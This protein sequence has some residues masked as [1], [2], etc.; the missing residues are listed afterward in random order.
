MTICIAAIAKEKDKEYVVFSTDHMITTNMGQ[1][2]HSIVKYT[3]I[4]KHTIAMLAGH[5]LL[6]DDLIKFDNKNAKYD[7]IK[8]Q[9]F[10][11][12]KKKRKE[13][14]EN[15]IYNIV[16]IDHQCYIS[17]L[18]N[19]MMNPLIQ[20]ILQ[21]VTDFKLNTTVLLTGFDNSFVQI[22]AIE[23]TGILDFRP[24]NFHA[25]G[26]GYVQA[27]N[28]LLFQKHSKTDS[29]LNAIY[30]V[31]KAKRNAEVI[32]GVG[33]ET[34]ISIL[35]EKGIQQLSN[36]YIEVLNNI[37]SNEIQYGKNNENLNKIKI[38]VI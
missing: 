18:Q 8:K 30:N 32:V 6:F 34:D 14:I 11:N 23:E 3:Q 29:L 24:M 5:A 25:I 31:Y 2:E 13:I 10:E 9:I 33:K 16:G 4:N 21:K 7:D 26:S 38:G 17:S 28:T 35:S 15:E 27:V 19:Q 37:Y 12:F 1:F 20:S 22:T 36:E